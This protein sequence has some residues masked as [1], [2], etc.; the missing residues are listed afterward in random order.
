[1]TQAIS[2]SSK[3]GDPRH[4]HHNDVNREPYEEEYDG[5]DSV[6]NRRARN[7]GRQDSNINTIEM[8]M[9]LFKGRNDTEP[10]RYNNLETP[11]IHFEKKQVTG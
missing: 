4:R 7:R 3:W 9:S 8:Q 5:A 11:S 2:E 6:R 10:L 1:M